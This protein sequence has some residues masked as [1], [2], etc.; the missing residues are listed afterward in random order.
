MVTELR[1]ECTDAW[2]RCTD[3]EAESARL[4][5]YWEVRTKGKTM[6]E[7]EEDYARRLAVA[8]NDLLDF[9]YPGQL[10]IDEPKSRMIK[11]ANVLYAAILNLP[12]DDD[13]GTEYGPG[14]S[15]DPAPD[16][17]DERN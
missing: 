1:Y 10:P 14:G 4:R 13:P 7:R 9:M 8:A 12:D 2:T 3:A 17:N 16:A 15:V 11:L 5:R 6:H